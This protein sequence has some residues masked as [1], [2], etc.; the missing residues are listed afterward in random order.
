[1]KFDGDPHWDHDD[2]CSLTNLCHTCL[3]AEEARADGEEA[4]PVAWTSW[5][6]RVIRLRDVTGGDVLL[7]LYL[8]APGDAAQRGVPVRPRYTLMLT[9]LDEAFVGC[10]AD[11]V[12]TAAELAVTRRAGRQ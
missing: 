6:G 12:L 5:T 2:E 8:W 1:V 10:T 3:A 9:G 7:S 11:A 4:A